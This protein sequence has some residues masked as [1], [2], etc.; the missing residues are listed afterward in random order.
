MTA[1]PD[2][3]AI[4]FDAIEIDPA[5]APAPSAIERALAATQD[6]PGFYLIGD[7]GGRFV[8]DREFGVISLRDE[9]LLAREGDQVHAVRLRVVPSSGDSY[10]LEM[11]LRVTGM[12][13]QM[14]GAEDFGLGGEI[15]EAPAPLAPRAPVVPWTV[16]AAARGL[17]TKPALAAHGPYG[18][19]LQTTIPTTSQRVA[20]AFAEP[21]PA[22]APESAA[23]SL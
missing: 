14:L 2:P 19:L 5:R 7:A 4:N 10:E 12:V 3:F 22:P 23:W 1:P 6:R 11:E 21:I 17:E 16:F 18:A 9:A 15:A 13:P 20:I 8:V